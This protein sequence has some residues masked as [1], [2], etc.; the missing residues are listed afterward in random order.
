[1]GPASGN[2]WDPKLI[3]YQM[4]ALQASYYISLGVLLGGAHVLFGTSLSLDHFFTAKHMNYESATGWVGIAA[5]VMAALA[6]S[7][8]LVIVVEKSRKCLDFG[9]TI[10][11][12]HLLFCSATRGCPS[13]W[14]WWIV[15]IVSLVV[16]V[17]LGEYLCSRVEMRDIPLIAL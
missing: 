11:I 16:M 13:S 15:H 1:M 6:G 8:M 7:V 2:L 3:I 9:A 5:T 10:Y 4:L 14:D 17:V 12:F